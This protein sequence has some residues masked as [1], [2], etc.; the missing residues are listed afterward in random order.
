INGETVMVYEKPQL[1]ERDS[2]FAK[3]LSLNDGNIMLKE[4]TISLQS[5]SHPCDFRNVEVKILSKK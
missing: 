4:G 5:E 1:D 3:I 2:N